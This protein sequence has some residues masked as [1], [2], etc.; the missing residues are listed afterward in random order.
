MRLIS[1]FWRRLGGRIAVVAVFAL[2]VAM[3]DQSNAS[4]GAQASIEIP[5]HVLDAVAAGDPVELI[6]SG[7]GGPG[8]IGASLERAVQAGLPVGS[9]ALDAAAQSPS[10]GVVVGE[11]FTLID[12]VT[13]TVDSV[14]ALERVA[15]L[16]DVRGIGLGSE[17]AELHIDESIEITRAGESHANGLLGQGTTIAVIDGGVQADHP[18]LEDSITFEAC[19]IEDRVL[20]LGYCPGNTTERFG[21]GSAPDQTISHGTAVV[22]AIASAGILAPMGVAPEADVEVYKIFSDT[23]GGF[24]TDLI[25]ALEYIATDRP[26]VDVVNMSLGYSANFTGVC[27][28][29]YT[30]LFDA[31][32]VLRDRGVVS[33]ASSGNDSLA[34]MGAPACLSNVIS[35]AASNDIA[36]EPDF[37]E[38]AEFSNISTVTNLV[39]PGTS[40]ET[41]RL[42]DRTW[43]FQGTSIAAPTVAACAA[44]ARQSGLNTALA[45]EVRLLTPTSIAP[46][47]GGRSIPLVDCAFEGLPSGDVNCDDVR[48]V[49]DGLII[50]QYI[51]QIRTDAGGCPL[52]NSA[53]QLNLAEADINGDA[54]VDIIDALVVTQCVVGVGNDFC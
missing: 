12:A 31:V 40:V 53:T 33:I 20:E 21:P 52:G 3:P 25:R 37:G 45:V 5:Q 16:P 44:L 19:F 7:T 15:A 39:A 28:S 35:V 32:E 38:V 50:A 24:L 30:A 47:P 9:E 22:G 11:P 14:E 46:N 4:A 42:G 29:T 26:D 1:A 6:L 48:D 43:F 17:R 13:V 8:S 23:N 10:N 18:D 49:I 27:D 34:A 54:L 41:A 36:G 2:V 51:V